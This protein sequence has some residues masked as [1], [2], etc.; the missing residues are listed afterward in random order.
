MISI[1][2]SVNL[3]MNKSTAE[4]KKTLITI[5]LAMT[6]LFTSTVSQAQNTYKQSYKVQEKE[7]IYGIARKNNISVKELMDANP[8]MKEKGYELKLG[9]VIN[10]PTKQKP[11]PTTAKPSTPP[12]TPTKPA[13]TPAKPATPAAKPTTPVTKPT[14]PATTAKTDVTKRA[15]N[16]GV[17]LPLNN[18][19]LDG[20]RMVEY[21][22]G[23]LLAVDDL[24][25]KGISTNVFAWD[26]RSNTDINTILKD[27]N[28]EK[29]DIVFG[30]Y[31][32]GHIRAVS[33]YCQKHDIKLCIPFAKSASD[34]IHNT[35]IYKVYQNEDDVNNQTINVYTSRFANYH[36]VFVDVKDTQSTKGIFTAS[37]RNHLQNKKIDYNL[38]GLNSTGEEFAKAFDKQKRNIVIINSDSKGALSKT[39]SK[40]NALKSSHP[41]IRISLLG[42]N[43]WLFYYKE[44][45]SSFFKFDTYI[46]STYYYNPVSSRVKDLEKKYESTFK[47]HM[48]NEFPHI[49]IDAYD[50]AGFFISG[51]NKFG[52]AFD[53]SGKQSAYSPIQSPMHFAKVLN[54][55]M[56]NNFFMLIHYTNEKKIQAINF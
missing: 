2:L 56:Q 3:Q 23:I 24:K 1:R 45:L 11:Q 22:R 19:N 12:T 4:M 46:P 17:A 8:Q 13:T 5:T 14:A 54:G 6:A 41:E 50:H 27:P 26:M 7:T 39:I 15:V 16:I 49:A 51:L 31:Y 36:P 20:K 32:Q 44:F 53:G 55:G 33:T 21:Y 47:T 30:P 42:Y 43:T 38:T 40:L 37:L 10:I 25:K 34:I 29:C 52:N 28:F 18:S 35:H 48:I 9:E